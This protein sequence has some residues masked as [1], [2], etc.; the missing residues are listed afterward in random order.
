MKNLLSYAKIGWLLPAFGLM[1]SIQS[2]QKESE[3]VAPSAGANSNVTAAEACRSVCLVAGQSAPI[4]TVDVIKNAG[5]GIDI[6]YNSTAGNYLK[7]VHLEIFTSIGQLRDTKKLSGGGAIPGKFDFSRSY[8]VLEN[9]TSDTFSFTLAQLQAALGVSANTP[10]ECFY[11]AAHAAIYTG[12]TAWAGACTGNGNFAF[13]GNNW[14]TYFSFCMSSCTPPLPVQATYAWEDL[15]S[16]GNDADYND[17]V[18]GSSITTAASG[19]TMTLQFTAVARGSSYDHAF[20]FRI[21]NTGLTTTI[22]GS[23]GISSQVVGAYL[24]VTVF[25]STILALPPSG[26]SGAHNTV[27]EEPCNGTNSAS[28]TITGSLPSL[29]AIEPFISVYTDPT[30]APGTLTYDLYVKTISPSM[31]GTFAYVAN[32]RDPGYSDNQ[33][34][35]REGQ[36]FPSGIVTPENWKYPQERVAIFMAYPSFTSISAG[37]NPNWAGATNPLYLFN[38]PGI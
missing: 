17:L 11:I 4:G 32:T 19:T 10:V 31:P 33:L 6:T 26:P 30:R 36:T 12:Q 20:R 28:V 16:N 5:G 35:P 22:G 24:V 14:G 25:P 34:Q 3:V 18:I 38:C 9:K 7:E 15:G 21:P 37:F 1:L 29:N 8:T 27:K 13:E 2:C 23:S